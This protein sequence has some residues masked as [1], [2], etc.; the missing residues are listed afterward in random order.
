MSLHSALRGADDREAAHD[1]LRAFEQ[2][3]V[4][5]WAG[6]C[7]RWNDRPYRGKVGKAVQ[8]LR[9]AWWHDGSDTARQECID[10]A[11]NL[12]AVLADAGA[13]E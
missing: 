4:S 1:F 10:A 13:K 3:S 2:D 5:L 11:Q 9:K 7:I 8:R 12:Q 6:A